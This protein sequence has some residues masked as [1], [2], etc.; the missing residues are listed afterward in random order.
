MIKTLEKQ[1]K[2]MM[3]V[4]MSNIATLDILI[5]PLYKSDCNYTIYDTLS[6]IVLLMNA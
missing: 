5:G 2:K 3:V 6:F 1:D 4:M